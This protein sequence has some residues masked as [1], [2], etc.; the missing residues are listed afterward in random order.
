MPRANPFDFVR[1]LER[2]N[3]GFDPSTFESGLA[4]GA[5][6]SSFQGEPTVI[7]RE[8][9]GYRLPEYRTPVIQDP[10]QQY[11]GL[12]DLQ[13]NT[14]LDWASN[15]ARY[16]DLSNLAPV[17]VSPPGQYPDLSNAPPVMVTPPGAGRGSFPQSL[18]QMFSQLAGENWIGG[19]LVGVDPNTGQPVYNPLGTVAR[20]GEGG[21]RGAGGWGGFGGGATGIGGYVGGLSGGGQAHTISFY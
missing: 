13:N 10:S 5:P 12:G 17:D 20:S 3:A 19:E 6:T 14:A 7:V 9:T 15:A 4:T 1:W 2:Q 18:G 8:P 21:G 11:P 16:P